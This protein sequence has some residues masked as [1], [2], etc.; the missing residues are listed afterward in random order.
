[1]LSADHP[2]ANVEDIAIP[3]CVATADEAIAIL[4]ERHA[5]WRNH[6]QT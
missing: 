1:M 4:R 5:E 3:R 6:Q 2:L